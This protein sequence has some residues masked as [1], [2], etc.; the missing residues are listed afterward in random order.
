MHVFQ[1]SQRMDLDYWLMILL[2]SFSFASD[3]FGWHATWFRSMECEAKCVGKFQMKELEKE[4]N[5][6]NRF[7]I[8]M[9]KITCYVA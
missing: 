2:V 3:W 8:Y 9:E 5:M 7:D 4:C 1:Q 6:K